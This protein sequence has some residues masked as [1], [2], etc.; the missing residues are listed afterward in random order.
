M[1]FTDWQQQI[2]E[3]K[4]RRFDNLFENKTFFE[5]LYLT[6]QVNVKFNNFELG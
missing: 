5:R 4:I 1:H 3:I 6:S 2:M